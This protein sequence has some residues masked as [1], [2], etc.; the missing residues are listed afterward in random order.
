M[1]GRKRKPDPRIAALEQLHAHEVDRSTD[2]AKQLRAAQNQ[3]EYLVR[4]IRQMD[5]QIFSMSQLTAWESMR[6]HFRTLCD[7]MTARKVAESNRIADILRP[8]LIATYDVGDKH[9]AP[10]QKLIS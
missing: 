2:L 8:E 6:P 10:P 4:T 9:D 1:F 3:V 5:D 7:G